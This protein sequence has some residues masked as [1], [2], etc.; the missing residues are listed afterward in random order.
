MLRQ[1]FE[2][3]PSIRVSQFF[4]N[5]Y[6][7]QK[8]LFLCD[9][10]KMCKSKHQLLWK[11]HK[12][13][14]LKVSLKS[15]RPNSRLVPVDPPKQDPAKEKQLEQLK[16]SRKCAQLLQYRVSAIVLVLLIGNV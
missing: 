8:L 11:Q 12:D 3:Q 7:E 13:R 9:V 2:Y 15:Y 5:G 10:L 4:G 16:A 6:A 14:Q 1:E